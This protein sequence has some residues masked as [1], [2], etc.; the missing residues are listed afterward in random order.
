[1][2]GGAD[3]KVVAQYATFGKQL[4]IAFQMEDDILGIWGDEKKTG[5]PA[6][7]DILEKKK[8]LPIIFGLMK[9]FAESREGPLT[10]I[11]GQQRISPEDA[12]K[13]AEVLEEYG[14]RAY[15]NTLAAEAHHLA[16]AAL[17]STGIENEAQ[18]DLRMLAEKLLG[19]ES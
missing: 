7:S 3:E 4:G 10:R 2:L 12:R 16:M 18:A 6:A 9:E 14:A 11:F 19:R 1:L 17:E 8:T 13:A 15:T 5:K